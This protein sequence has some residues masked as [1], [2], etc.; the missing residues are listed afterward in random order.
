MRNVKKNKKR[1]SNI[2]HLMSEFMID[3]K[4]EVYNWF[5]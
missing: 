1:A 2:I 3:Y 4:I 5:K